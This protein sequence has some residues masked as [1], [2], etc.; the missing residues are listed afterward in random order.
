MEE[1]QIVGGEQ[2]NCVWKFKDN[3]IEKA[4]VLHHFDSYKG[5]FIAAAFRLL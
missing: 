5:L 1:T 4:E 2:K 3:K